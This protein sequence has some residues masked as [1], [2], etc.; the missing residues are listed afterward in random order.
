MPSGVCDLL[1]AMSSP[2]DWL[3]F[4]ML[5]WGVLLV[6]E[7]ADEDSEEAVRLAVLSEIGKLW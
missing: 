1:L 2:L 7:A 6:D 5:D 3:L 4:R